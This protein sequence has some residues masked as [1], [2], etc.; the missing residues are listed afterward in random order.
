VRIE[1]GAGRIYIIITVHTAVAGGKY[2]A[3]WVRPET[4]A[5]LM[6]ARAVLR[7]RS[8]DETVAR[9]LE[10]CMPGL[11]RHAREAAGAARA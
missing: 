5:A 10:R 4:F 1:R 2:R 7:A 6:L 11:L 9:L 3:V 8:M